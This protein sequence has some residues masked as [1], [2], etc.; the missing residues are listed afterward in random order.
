MTTADRRAFLNGTS[1]AA[2]GTVVGLSAPAAPAQIF[3]PIT[4]TSSSVSFGWEARL[5]GNGANICFRVARKMV[6]N[7]ANIDVSFMILSAPAVG[8]FAEVLCQAS[9]S[10]GAVPNFDNSAHAYI[11]PPAS[12][13]FD[14]AIVCNPNNLDVGTNPTL[15]QDMFYAVILKGWV[16]QDGTGSAQSR[17][18]RLDPALIVNAG[19]Y[20]VFHM[21][22]GGVPVDAEMQVVLGY[23][24]T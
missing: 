8:G 10:R 20:L 6:L 15:G 11:G 17:Q 21:D 9:V 7:S 13:D 19:D 22:H 12:P 1:I 14:G 2:I 24:L 23:R 3:N 18:A 4:P 5:H 16:P